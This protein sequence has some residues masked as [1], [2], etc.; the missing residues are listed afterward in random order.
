[1][2]IKRHQKLV[3]LLAITGMSLALPVYSYPSAVTRPS[4]GATPA[5]VQ[6]DVFTLWLDHGP[7]PRNAGYAYIVL[8]NLAP[9]AIEAY[10]RKSGIA[11]WLIPPKYR[12]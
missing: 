6:E 4:A 7:K 12:P 2:K 5:E 1:M 8:P 11:Y 9:A 3:L 10:R